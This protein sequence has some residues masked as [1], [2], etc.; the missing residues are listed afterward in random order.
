MAIPDGLTIEQIAN[1]R[2]NAIEQNQARFT[3]ELKAFLDTMTAAI[4]RQEEF[5]EA[6]QTRSEKRDAVI[7]EH[8]NVLVLLK[9]RLDSGTCLVSP[10]DGCPVVSTMAANVLDQ[11]VRVREHAESIT[12]LQGIANRMTGVC[13]RMETKLVVHGEDMASLK[14]RVNWGGVIGGGIAVGI[15][16]WLVNNIMGLTTSIASLQAATSLMNAAGK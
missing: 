9:A 4:T 6:T 8:G 2:L 16:A 15:A 5:N 11:E 13:E 7:A 10:K 1:G 3:M 14:T 12:I